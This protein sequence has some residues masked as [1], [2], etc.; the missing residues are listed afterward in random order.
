MGS[1]VKRKEE[2]RIQAQ[3]RVRA[4][5]PCT[6][7]ASPRTPPHSDPA[8]GHTRGTVRAN[9]EREAEDGA[10]SKH[11]GGA[12]ASGL[13]RLASAAAGTYRRGGRGGRGCCCSRSFGTCGWCRAAGSSVGRSAGRRVCLQLVASS[14]LLGSER[15]FVPTAMALGRTCQ[16]E[17]ATAT[18]N[19]RRLAEGECACRRRYVARSNPFPLTERAARAWDRHGR[20]GRGAP[21]RGGR[22]GR[23][24]PTA[25]ALAAPARA[26]PAAQRHRS[27]ARSTARYRSMQRHWSADAL[28]HAPPRHMPSCRSCLAGPSLSGAARNITKVQNTS[29]HKHTN[30]ETTPRWC[31][32]PA[33]V[34]C[35]AGTAGGVDS[36]QRTRACFSPRTRASS[37]TLTRAWI[38]HPHLLR[39]PSHAA[40]LR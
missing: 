6:S 25:A 36:L 19:G 40:R 29:A 10:A 22:R 18:G 38:M 7:R 24:G 3:P 27:A 11:G 30:T 26:G 12:H 39:R 28:P 8:N 15:A 31:R 9:R 20:S 4:Q 33:R 32:L 5:R 21:C 13:A 2:R 34:L 17:T 35:G 16:A 1:S 23:D 14:I 37:D